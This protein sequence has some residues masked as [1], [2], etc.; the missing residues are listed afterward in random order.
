MLKIIELLAKK[1]LYR[2]MP[3]VEVHEGF[4]K[5]YD[6]LAPQMWSAFKKTLV[7]AIN[8]IPIIRC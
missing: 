5:V 6:S 1:V 2:G 8:K 4:L 7:S 3:G